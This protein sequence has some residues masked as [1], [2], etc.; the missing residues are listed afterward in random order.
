LRHIDGASSFRRVAWSAVAIFLHLFVAFAAIGIYYVAGSIELKLEALLKP[1]QF[2][3]A[4]AV[5]LKLLFD[6]GLALTVATFTTLSL[7]EFLKAAKEVPR[8]LRS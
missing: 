3:K 4:V 6:F 1:T 5:P 7:L 8:L 2:Q